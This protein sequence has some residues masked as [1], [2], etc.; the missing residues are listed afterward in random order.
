MRRRL[1]VLAWFFAV[2]SAVNLMAAGSL[3]RTDGWVAADE[4]STPVPVV[5]LYGF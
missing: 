4:P 2:F 5:G 1:L 3:A